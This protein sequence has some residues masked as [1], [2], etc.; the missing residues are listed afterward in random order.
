MAT[1]E[2]RVSAE[3][4]EKLLQKYEIYITDRWLNYDTSS[5]EF[6]IN[7]EGSECQGL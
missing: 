5:I 3:R 6:T 4:V 2:Y 7:L 1:C